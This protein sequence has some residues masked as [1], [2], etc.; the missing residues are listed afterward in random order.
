MR[1]TAS[2]QYT[3]L[4]CAKQD[5]M[6]MLDAVVMNTNRYASAERRFKKTQKKFKK[7][8]VKNSYRRKVKSRAMKEMKEMDLHAKNRDM[9]YKAFKNAKSPKSSKRRTKRR[10]KHRTKRRSVRKK[11]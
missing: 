4:G 9:W 2:R 7:A 5:K 1:S 10:T 11:R 8:T 6:C 3:Q